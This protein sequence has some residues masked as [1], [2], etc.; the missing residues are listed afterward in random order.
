MTMLVRRASA[1]G[2][3]SVNAGSTVAEGREGALALLRPPGAR[4][5]CLLIEPQAM[6]RHGLALMLGAH[7]AGLE[8]QEAATV[9]QGL[10]LLAGRRAVDLVLVDIDALAGDR[11]DSLRRL[12]Q[13]M[14]PAATLVSCAQATPALAR[15]CLAAG[16]RGFVAKSDPSA[17]LELVTD[18]LLRQDERGDVTYV[19]IPRWAIGGTPA[20]GSVP[21]RNEGAAAL[22]ALTARQ[23][24]IFH[25]L[26]A[27]CSNKEIARRL[28]VLEGTVKV[29][30]R[31]VMGR[32]G[33]K[34]RTQVAI[35]AA[36][37][38]QEPPG[39]D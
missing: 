15:A 32:L 16:A 9:E 26:Q 1:V 11:I 29:H 14:R 38:A 31:A 37:A 2:G 6:V 39:R 18:L 3:A 17:V 12:V 28:G 10:A 19:Q 21:G 25:L 27:G 36:R 22:E 7:Q 24:E 5:R 33:L 35:L 34:N 20:G 8:V 4:A 13:D 23:R 30:V